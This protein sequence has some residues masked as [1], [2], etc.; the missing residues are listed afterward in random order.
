MINFI[1]NTFSKNY[2]IIVNKHVQNS[3]TD[4]RNKTTVYIVY[5]QHFNKSNKSI[6]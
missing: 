3:Y 2:I 1:H 6:S 5:T 4:T